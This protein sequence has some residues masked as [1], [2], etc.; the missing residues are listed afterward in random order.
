MPPVLRGMVARQLKK[1]IV[2]AS[3][4]GVVAGFAWKFIHVDP[5]RRK[6][7]AFYKNYDAEKV[8]K[9]LEAELESSQ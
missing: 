1:D 3:V 8:A 4:M 7:E 6:Y 5:K 2:V 9:E